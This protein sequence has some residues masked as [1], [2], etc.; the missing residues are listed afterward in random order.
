MAVADIV[1]VLAAITGIPAK[2]V[3]AEMREAISEISQ[4]TG[5]VNTDT[6]T[7][8]IAAFRSAHPFSLASLQAG[9]KAKAQLDASDPR[10][11]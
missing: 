6:F 9:Q 8:S 5:R 11:S 10:S 2:Q 4:A 7:A 1:P 3:D